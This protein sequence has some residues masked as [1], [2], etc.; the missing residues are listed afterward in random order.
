M[1]KDFNI[2]K[3]SVF[4]RVKTE[5]K[6]IEEFNN[7]NEAKR[8]RIQCQREGYYFTFCMPQDGKWRLYIG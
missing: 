1:E 6:K 3:N 2:Y 4:E 8:R 5:Y 7:K